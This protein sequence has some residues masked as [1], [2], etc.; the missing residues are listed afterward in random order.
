M[1]S[2]FILL[3]G[4][5]ALAG[6]LNVS[7]NPLIVGPEEMTV[8]SNVLIGDTL[9]R[10]KRPGR[11]SYYTPTSPTEAVAYP[12]LGSPIRRHI[13]YWRESLGAFAEDI[14]LTAGTSVYAIQNRT[15]AAVN[16]SSTN[17]T[18]LSSSDKPF[19]QVFEGVLFMLH[20]GAANAAHVYSKWDGTTYTAASVV[21]ATAPV[22]GPGSMMGTF[23][24]RMVMA[25][26]VNFPFRLY[27]SAALD[28]ETWTGADTTSLDFNY[29]GES[30]GITAILGELQGRLYIATADS[31]YELSAT[32]L[33][34]PATFF[35]RRVTQGIGC[36]GPRMFAR[37]AND[38][39]FMS[40]RGLHS[41]AKTITSDQVDLT[42]VSRQVQRIFTEGLFQGA[43]AQGD[44]V[45][46][47]NR[48]LILCSVPSSGQVT[49]DVTL[50]FNNNFGIWSGVWD[51]IDARSLST[52][53]LSG[54]RYVSLGREDGKLDL[55][56]GSLRMD[57]GAG[58]A[59]RFKTGKIFPNDDIMRQW[60]FVSLGLLMSSS[61]ASTVQISWSIDGTDGTRTGSDSIVLGESSTLLGSTFILGSSTLGIGQFVPNRVTVGDIG[62]N[63]Q[64]EIVVTGNSDFEYYG[65]VLEVE[66]ADAHYS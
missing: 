46:D 56:D 10:K 42:F 44:M 9:A 15:A 54:K 64:L 61:N 62:Y 36:V 52:V 50:A 60:R 57:R 12:F 24:S 31:V 55:L 66:G 48:N 43:L 27:I 21:T 2:E 6:G 18:T 45:W 35:I 51:D 13:Q 26:N 30:D 28:A 39:I 19:Y 49:N 14:V 29:D 8:A 4:K 37:T 23:Q 38:I 65:C 53:K 59:A 20:P 7:D 3:M 34:D 5:K 33:T 47:Q 16:I 63:I 58:F 17:L 40:D 25:G 41:L 1:A 11:M 22:D 32:D